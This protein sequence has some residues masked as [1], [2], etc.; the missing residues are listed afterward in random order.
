MTPVPRL[1]RVWASTAAL[2]TLLSVASGAGGPRDAAAA[3][4]PLPFRVGERL[5]FA[6][7]WFG[8]SAGTSELSVAERTVYAG[9]PVLRLT[10]ITRSNGFISA[11]YPVDD[12]F[13]SLWDPVERHPLFY[14]IRQ[15]EG[16]YR[17][18]K[19]VILDQES[20]WAFY[21]R[22]DDP[23]WGYVIRYGVQDALSSLYHLRALGGGH[24]AGGHVRGGRAS[25]GHT[26]GG[27]IRVGS[28]IR[29]LAFAS[30]K[31]W[32]SVVHIEAREV[33][34]TRWGKIPT[35]RVRPKIAY[36][37]GP[38][39]RKG[40]VVF[41]ATDDRY[42]IPVRM[43]SVV[44]VIGRVTARLVKAEGIAEDSL[45]A[46]AIRKSRTRPKGRRTAGLKSD[47]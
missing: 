1:I 12:R 31:N 36:H 42:R 19:D 46:R 23:A 13:E 43:S 41:W 15:R 3:E 9:T 14:R 20:N 30:K 7:T 18:R 2:L 17:S 39:R 16:T 4:D 45:L 29:V 44:M 35:L 38:F 26:P 5:T 22:N 24:A 11:F 40:E 25:G 34:R 32:E 28:R 47:N 6:I 27:R 10:S 8:I 37:E 33:L 21:K